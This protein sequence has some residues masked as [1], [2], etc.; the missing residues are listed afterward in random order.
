MTPDDLAAGKNG[1][2]AGHEPAGAEDEQR[3][4]AEQLR[5]AERRLLDEIARHRRAEREQIE[6]VRLGCIV[7]AVVLAVALLIG[8]FI[9]W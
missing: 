9:T 6:K 2:P 4:Q 1:G 7:V 3:K 8:F 5:L